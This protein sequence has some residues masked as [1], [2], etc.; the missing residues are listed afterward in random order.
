MAIKKPKAP[1]L[2]DWCCFNGCYL[3]D[4][5]A[6]TSLNSACGRQVLPLGHPGLFPVCCAEVSRHALCTLLQA[7]LYLWSAGISVKG[8]VGSVL[9][10]AEHVLSV[11]LSQIEGQQVGTDGPVPGKPHLRTRIIH[12][13]QNIILPLTFST[14]ENVKTILSWGL[15]KNRRSV[16][17]AHGPRV[18]KPCSLYG[19]VR[20]PKGMNLERARQV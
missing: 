15:Y 3:K 5:R 10:F 20:T 18:S 8:R 4:Y 6:T 17:L 16:A 14:I 19:R 13:P 7:Q 12:I 11:L 1:T 9:G 2:H